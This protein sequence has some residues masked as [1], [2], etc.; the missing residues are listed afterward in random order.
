MGQELK[1]MSKETHFV[2]RSLDAVKAGSLQRIAN[3]TELMAKN[4]SNLIDERDRYKRWYE[5][6]HLREDSANRRIV[7]LKGVITRIK[8][9]RK[10]L[11]E[12]R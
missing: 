10:L 1:E 4:Y 12:S 9:R 5:D 6:A 11:K 2:D 8:N 7:A 3:A